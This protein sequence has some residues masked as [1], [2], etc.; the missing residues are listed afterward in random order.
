[1]IFG[2]F[3]NCKCKSFINQI[4]FKYLLH[5]WLCVH[6]GHVTNANVIGFGRN[7]LA[8]SSSIWLKN[9]AFEYIISLLHNHWFKSRRS[10]SRTGKDHYEIN[11]NHRGGANFALNTLTDR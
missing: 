5:T 1:M 6:V 7:I 3:L 8:H 9:E 10:I 2:A 4:K 11:I